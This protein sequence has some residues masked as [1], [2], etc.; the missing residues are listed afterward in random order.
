MYQY[1][2]NVPEESKT[3]RW[4]KYEALEKALEAQ[5]ISLGTFIRHLRKDITGL[6][7]DK[8][9][10]AAK[11]SKRTLISIE[12]GK[13]NPS[14]SVLQSILSCFGYMVGPIKVKKKI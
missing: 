8:M 12:S 3:E 4:K 2:K 5:E 6:S 14:L 13:G 10:V 9:A 11:V 7:L 1:Q